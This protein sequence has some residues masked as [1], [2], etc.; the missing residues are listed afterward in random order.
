VSTERTQP[1]PAGPACCSGLAL[2]VLW[3]LPLVAEA[4]DWQFTPRVATTQTITDNVV[5]SADDPQSDVV[6]Q[7]TPGFNLQ[8]KSRRLKARVDYS[9]SRFAYVETSEFNRTT[10]QVQASGDVDVWTEWLKMTSNMTR[11]Q[12]VVSQNNAVTNSVAVAPSNTVEV[13][14]LSLGPVFKHRFGR[15]LEV[16]ASY[17]YSV[18]QTDGAA[19]LGNSLDTKDSLYSFKASSGQV[20]PRLPVSLSYTSR[21]SSFDAGG[22]DRL[23]QTTLQ[24]S[25]VVNR[26]FRF[27]AS[28]GIDENDFRNAQ[29]DT[30]GFNWQ[31]GGTWTPTPR[32]TFTL[33]YGKR[34][35]GDNLT[36]NASWKKRRLALQ[37]G[38][39]ETVTTFSSRQENLQLIPETDLFGEPINDPLRGG[40]PLIIND[41]ASLTDAVSVN[42]RLT[43]NA[44]LN[45]RRD[46]FNAAVSRDKREAQTTNAP[47]DEAASTLSL[48]WRRQLTPLMSAGFTTQV[49]RSSFSQGSGTNTRLSLGP[50]F[51]YRLASRLSGNVSYR[52]TDSEGG[53]AAQEYRENRLVG[54]LSLSF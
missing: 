31:A 38:Y 24:A 52:Y 8:G 54:V 26:D 30:S 6:S 37:A 7:I 13:T 32:A 17:R 12:Q 3:L 43:F 35:F 50:D 51:N 49:S 15:L 16:D 29:N 47:Q 20:L 21:K 53:A 5:L 9:L 2:V 14:S 36:F 48:G 46:T 33:G 45:G 40:D 41:R 34:F 23:R 10:H 44:Q 28:A 39:N 22:A 11:S 42:R 1:L 18:T 25:Y 27:N 4:G 19:G